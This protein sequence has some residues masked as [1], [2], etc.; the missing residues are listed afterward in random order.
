[1]NQTWEDGKKKLVWSLILACFGPKAQIQSQ[2][3]F[4][5]GFTS[6][7]ILHIVASYHWT[8]FQGKLMNQTW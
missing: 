8:L 4:F 2:N 5:M 3:F 1:M 7:N 6:T